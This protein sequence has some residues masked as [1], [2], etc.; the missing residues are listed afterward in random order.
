MRTQIRNLAIPA[1][2]ASLALGCGASQPTAT[3]P[4][5]TVLT[6]PSAPEAAHKYVVV[7]LS[8][9]LGGIWGEAEKEMPGAREAGSESRCQDVTHMTFPASSHAQYQQFRAL[10]PSAV[11]AFVARVQD[12]A[13]DDPVDKARKEN[14]A[15]L[16]KA[17][18][19]ESRE[20]LTARRAAHRVV[21][22]E[23]TADRATLLEDEAKAV[24]PLRAHAALEALF[25]LDAGDLTGDARAIGLLA[26]VDRIAY[27]RSLPRHLKIIALSDAMKLVFGVDPP[28]MPEDATSQL[29][30]AELLTFMMNAA[31][32]GGHPVPETATTPKDKYALAY[33]G[34]LQGL[35][36]KLKEAATGLAPTT[37]LPKILNTMRA[38]IEEHYKLEMAKH[39]ATP[40]P[41]PQP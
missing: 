8:C 17:T 34:M 36:D 30:H 5:G 29:R 7:A 22:D 32:A 4:G 13:G 28:A 23:G 40:A 20:L 39:A 1:L 18:A 35:A 24:G 31:K 37:E 15:K 19:E 25:H 2:L 3:Q 9:W 16:A 6:A 11:D 27:A 12:I 21:K 33:A 14:L 41:A 38:K 26:V 10:D